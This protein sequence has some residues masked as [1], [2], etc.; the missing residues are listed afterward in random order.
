[1]LAT[2]VASMIVLSF[3]GIQGQDRN[4]VQEP[5]ILKSS[6]SRTLGVPD[7]SAEDVKCDGNGHLF[8][9]LTAANFSMNDSLVMR[10]DLKSETPTV[11]EQPSDYAGKVNLIDFSLTPAGQIWYLDEMK[12]GSGYVAFGFDSDGEV[13]THVN[14][15]IP[16]TLLVSKFAVSDDTSI[17][18]GGFF[19]KE[20]PKEL[21]GKSYLAFF[22]KTG[23]VVRDAGNNLPDQDLEAFTKGAYV[24]TAV[25]VGV[26]G[27][28]YIL[29]NGVIVV[30]SEAG[31][32]VHRFKFRSP[33][34]SA[35]LHSMTVSADLLSVEFL[36]PF[37]KFL[38]P[39]FVVLQSAT[40]EPYA[41][42]QPSEELGHVCLCFSR[43]DGY[44]F[45]R[46]ENGKIKLINAPL[47]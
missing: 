44:L 4:S 2:R 40:G 13:R 45:S 33:G 9:R 46:I 17:L 8:Y 21:R 14:L 36:I 10:L 37:G 20:A 15:D 27:N 25:A 35:H 24:N 1:M 12:D 5:T 43:R 26:D 31:E 23:A 39:V 19:L 29:D 42:Y 7:I 16:V 41:T 47:R 34:E 11:Y 28:F 3:L 18:V 6:G 32:I 30:M 22:G 38:S